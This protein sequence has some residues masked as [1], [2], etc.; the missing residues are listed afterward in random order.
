[1]AAKAGPSTSTSAPSSAPN[2]YAKPNRRAQPAGVPSQPAKIAK[3]KRLPA[4]MV[5]PTGSIQPSKKANAKDKQASKK[6]KARREEGKEK[7][8]ELA[9]RLEEKVKGREERK[10]K[11]NRA[12][13]AWE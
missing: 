8:V 13:N 7:A 10:A 12:K 1:M 6:Q 9:K 11:R 5:T 4:T 2:A 3:N